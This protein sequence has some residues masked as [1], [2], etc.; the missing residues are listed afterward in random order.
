MAVNHAVSRSAPAPFDDAARRAATSWSASTAGKSKFRRCVLQTPGPGRAPTGVEAPT[1]SG[2]PS[3]RCKSSQRNLR[4]CDT[5]SYASRRARVAP[6]AA[7]RRRPIRSQRA[8]AHALRR[9]RAAAQAVGSGC[10]R[11]QSRAGPE[12]PQ[13][14]HHASS[15]T[16]REPAGALMVEDKVGLACGG[17]GGHLR[18]QERVSCQGQH[19]HVEFLPR[20]RAAPPHSREGHCGVRMLPRPAPGGS[21]GQSRA[22]VWRRQGIRSRGVMIVEGIGSEAV[23][24]G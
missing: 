5:P 16:A 23:R 13:L 10:R 24:L 19:A 4:R 8:A 12:S 6:P 21:V 9:A 3:R 1:P 20:P 11:A 7:S 15:N 22:E 17:D 18:A 2:A 14:Q